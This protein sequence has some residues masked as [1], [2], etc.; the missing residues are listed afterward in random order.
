MAG[1]RDFWRLLTEYE[2]LTRNESFSIKSEDFAEV[3]AIQKCKDSI[4]AKLQA[5]GA[6]CGLDRRNS[7]LSRR[8]DKLIESE[9]R[10]EQLLGTM[11]VRACTKLRSLDATRSR[12]RGLGNSY[13]SEKSEHRSFSALV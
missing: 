2:R 3:A 12:L 8:M 11:A 13:V 6:E 5:L 7:E 1:E 4:L 9:Q 10:N